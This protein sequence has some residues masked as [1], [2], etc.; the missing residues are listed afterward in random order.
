MELKFQLEI[1]LVEDRGLRNKLEYLFWSEW[2]ECSGFVVFFYC[3]LLNWT[4]GIFCL[5]GLACLLKKY[6]LL[7]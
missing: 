5:R 1:K 3:F 4:G 2:S 6:A 7:L